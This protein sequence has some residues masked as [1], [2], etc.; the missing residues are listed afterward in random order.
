MLIWLKNQGKVRYRTF[1]LR[2]Q[3]EWEKARLACDQ[4]VEADPAN[5]KAVYRRALASEQLG[6]IDA[7]RA[8]IDAVL[9]KSRRQ[10]DG[11]AK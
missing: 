7:A 4:A 3:G 8:D 10:P 2:Q 5:V 11:T 6:Q 1:Q 9:S